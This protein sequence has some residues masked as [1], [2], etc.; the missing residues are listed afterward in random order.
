[1]DGQRHVVGAERRKPSLQCIAVETIRPHPVGGLKAKVVLHLP[2]AAP[3]RNEKIALTAKSD[4][5][6]IAIDR[7]IRF[8]AAEER[9]PV[10]GH[11]DVLGQAEELP[12]AAV[13]P[14]RC[15]QG[16]G[17]VRLD[18]DDVAAPSP[19]CQ[20]IGDGGAD[21]TAADY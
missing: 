18:D 17:R 5:G 11:R 10:L 7:H 2:L 15:R 16:I 20:M 13:A 8:E 1:M 12:D 4:G 9:Q 14:R 3:V 6:G 19:A 21:D